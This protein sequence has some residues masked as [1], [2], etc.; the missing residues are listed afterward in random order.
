M[1]TSR[2]TI[3]SLPVWSAGEGECGGIF[4]KEK[5]SK[6]AES[7]FLSLTR[8]PGKPTNGPLK[9]LSMGCLQQDVPSPCEIAYVKQTHWNLSIYRVWFPRKHLIISVPKFKI[10]MFHVQ[11]GFSPC[12]HINPYKLNLL[13]WVK[14]MT[15]GQERIQGVVLV[16]PDLSLLPVSH[17]YL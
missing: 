10:M 13:P 2:T 8:L 16:L 3:Y 14:S 4:Q 17:N 11:I 7:N 12:S 6:V 5:N 1:V 9:I 15:W